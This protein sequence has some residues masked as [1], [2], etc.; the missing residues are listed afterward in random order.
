MPF[1]TDLSDF[2]FQSRDRAIWYFTIDWKNRIQ[3]DYYYVQEKKNLVHVLKAIIDNNDCMDNEL[4]GVWNGQYS[5]DIF[6]IPIEQG[7]NELNKPVVRL[8]ICVN[9]LNYI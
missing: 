3:K 4:F 1:R 2:P 8:Q 9:I 7:Y 6:K 5:T